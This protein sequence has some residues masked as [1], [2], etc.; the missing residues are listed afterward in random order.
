MRRAP[1]IV[2]MILLVKRAVYWLAADYASRAARVDPSIASNAN[3]AAAAYRG[4]A[5]QKS[6]VFQ[7]SKNAGDPISIGCWIG[8][9][10][11]IPSL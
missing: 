4:R 1:I 7:S 10:V 6:D 2:V 5:P 11:R 8:E 3:Q 9:T